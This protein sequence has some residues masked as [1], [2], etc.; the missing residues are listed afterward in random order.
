MIRR[1]VVCLA[2]ASGMAMAQYKMEPAGGPPSEVSPQM[3]QALQKEGFKIVNAVG[4]VICEVWFRSAAPTGPKSS[5]PNVTLPTI[6]HGAFLGVIRYPA[7]YSDRR[8]LTVKPDV[9]TLRYSLYPANG[10]HQGVSPQRDFAILSLASEDKDVNATPDFD[11]LMDMSRKASGA[12]HPLTLSFYASSAEKFPSFAKEGDKDW[13]LN[14]K[15]GDL[16]VALI[17]IGKYEG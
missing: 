11:H 8:G 13:V 14:A 3:A 2:L 15:M 9:Y 1:A 7:R 6:P 5:E 4:T 17:L 12:P 16:A 10:D